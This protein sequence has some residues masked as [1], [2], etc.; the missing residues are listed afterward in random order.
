MRRIWPFS[1]SFLWF[2]SV[3]LIVPFVVLYYQELGFTGPQIGLLTGIAPLIM[4]VGAPFWT[5]IAD[6]RRKHRLIMSTTLLMGILALVIYP[7]VSTFVAIM[8]VV[9]QLNFFLAPVQSFADS[10]TMHMLRDEKEMYGRIRLGGTIGY[11]LFAPI[12]GLLV[13]EQG[14]KFAF[15]GSAGVMFLSFIISQ[16]FVYDQLRDDDQVGGSLRP[17]LQNPR[18]TLF[19]TIALTGGLAL[20]ATNNY[21]FPL[22]K[23]LGADESIMGYALTIGTIG[24]VPILFFGNRLIKRF[25]SYRLLVL[26]MIL[27]GIRLLLLAVSGS[28]PVVLLVQLLNGVN[29]PMMWIAGVAFADEY[30]PPGMSASAQGLFG[31]M[32][33]GIGNALGGF[34][35]GILLERIGGSGLYLVFGILVLATIAVVFLIDQRLPTE[36]EDPN[37][38]AGQAQ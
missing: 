28:P 10:A 8:A 3:A 29:I 34:L 36:R 21:L 16:K 11:G 38:I 33:T 31:A 18:W 6:A 30:A 4:F 19:L 20:A 14:L 32:V 5:G 37:A 26:A 27:T 1:F 24:E 15:W 17:L 13:K 35:G 9:I 22:M 2:A 12:A 23:E 7:L 25:K